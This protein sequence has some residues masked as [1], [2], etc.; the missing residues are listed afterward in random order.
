METPGWLESY[1]DEKIRPR[2]AEF[3]PSSLNSDMA[4][5]LAFSTLRKEE[6]W[7]QEQAEANPFSAMG[8]AALGAVDPQERRRILDIL[9]FGA[10]LVLSTYA[11]GQFLTSTDL[12]LRTAAAIAHNRG[13]ADFC[14]ADRRLL[15]VGMVPLDDGP[16][17]KAVLD[18]ALSVGCCAIWIAPTRP[19]GNSPSH[20]DFDPFWA[21]LA[22]AD[23][24]FLLHVGTGGGQLDPV[25]NRN[26]RPLPADFLGGGEN[27]RSK[28]FMVAHQLPETILSVLVLDGVLD[29]FPALRG[30][31]V[32]H[33]AS[34]VPA[35]MQRLDLAH[36]FF[37]KTEETLAK[38][39]LRPS[40]Y[41]RDRLKF[42]PMFAERVAPLA[43][44]EPGLFM[45][46]TDYPHPEGGRDP[47]GA[48]ETQ[49]ADTP[50][51]VQERFYTGNFAE[52]LGSRLPAAEAG[53]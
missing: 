10:Q 26:G 6:R 11:G 37:R 1:A 21:T 13:V 33:G 19:T 34:W 15:P 29:R 30:A 53:A 25:F 40:E 31:C 2:L 3:G 36:G 50:A 38:L 16:S 47:L 17:A 45:F 52:L 28:D 39:R 18:H 27:M 48:F 7:L 49:L 12:E 51:D 46:S 42:T 41:V 14:S 22:E 24:P 35:W 5:A 23:T 9:G 8:W 43:T 44:A 20:P 32:E 4:D